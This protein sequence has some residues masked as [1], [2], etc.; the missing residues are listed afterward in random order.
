MAQ[1]FPSQ[2]LGVNVSA[3][4]GLALTGT[5]VLSNSN[6]VTF[7]MQ[8]SASSYVVTASV[9]AQAVGAI[10]A[11]TT[12][13]SSG[14]I[15]LSDSNGFSFGVAGQTVTATYE[16]RVTAFSQ[17]A[18]FGTNF[19]ISNASLSIQKMSIPMHLSASQAVILMDLSGNSGSS[20]ALTV[21]M[22]FYTLSGST[23]SLATSASRQISWTSGSATSASSQYGGASG[24]RY[25]TLGINVSLTPGDYMMGF[26]FRTTNNGTWRVF[27]RQAVNLVG[28]YDG[29]ETAYFLDGTSNASFTTA[30]PSSVVVTDTNYARTGAPA[31][32]QP[33]VILI[34]TF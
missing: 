16:R 3:G 21:S 23:A 8:T 29:V 26:H 12:L 10:S 5:V 28:T 2:R 9:V 18:E 31:M 14:T 24:T 20:G 13:A 11:G 25:R 34:G 17:W 1:G 15:V 7:G 4:T 30:F 22:A 33:G 6:G 19:S 32:R 27:G